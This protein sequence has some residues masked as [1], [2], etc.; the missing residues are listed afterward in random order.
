ML[1]QRDLF[2]SGHEAYHTFRIPSILAT[3][4]GSLLAFCEGRRR[5]QGD[6]GDIDILLRRSD[7]GG[8]TWSPI[9]T[10]W[11]DPGNTC[12]NPCPVVDRQS[13]AISLLLTHNLG[14][15][16][17]HQII[18]GSSEGTRTVWLTRSED[19][20]HTWSPPQNITRTT[21]EADWTWYATGPGAGIQLDSGRLVVPCDHIEATSKKY[22]SHVILSDDGGISWFLGGTTPQDQVNECEVV[23]LD[24][25]NLLLNMRNY[26]RNQRARAV[27][28]SDDEGLSWS[29]LVRKDE[30]IEPICQ[31]S[32]R[33]LD[34]PEGTKLLF[35]NPASEEKREN[36]TVRM[37]DDD[38]QTWPYKG[39]LHAGP[40]AYSCL[41]ALPNG[42]AGCLY[43]C[44]E[45]S[46]Y[47]TIRF[48]QFDLSWLVD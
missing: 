4:A 48:A 35:A 19:D 37:S 31:A 14:T 21:K 38:G 46:P 3:Q 28:H 26:D 6:S 16:V 5:G 10:V 20:G 29:D 15:D 24:N 41:V 17:E 2:T 30:L 36:M 45:N 34:T 25:G 12:G 22:F 23:Q 18:E 39:T 47:E 43:E 44:G 11:A 13:G 42:H 32:L 33:R 40:A 27:C 9:Q 7:D 1:I 8:Q